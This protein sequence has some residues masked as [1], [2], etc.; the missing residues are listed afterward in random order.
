LARSY[1]LLLF[2]VALG[3]A[4]PPP[5]PY[6]VE[7]Y[8]VRIDVDIVEKRLA[9]E[10]TM[11]LRS[12]TARLSTLEFDA[13][14]LDVA[15]VEESQVPQRFER[16]GRLLVVTLQRVLSAGELRKLTM[17]YQAKPAKGLVFFPDQVY[18]SFF[19]NDWMVC[20]DRPEDRATLRLVIA[21]PAGAKVTGSGRLTA[22]REEGGRSISEW[23]LDSATPPFVFGFA[24]GDYV[25]SSGATGGVKLRYLGRKTAGATVPEATQAALQFLSE[26]TGQPF[27]GSVYT[28]VFTSGNVMQEV[29][30]FTLMPESYAEK[31]VTHPDDLW[32]LVHEL[33][34]QWYGIGI[35]CRDWSD[36]WLN[37]GI[38]TYVADAF[39][40]QR[41][42]RERYER[43]IE[44]SRKTYEKL[45][46]E[47]KDRPLSYHD[48]STT[49]EAGGALPYHKGAWVLHLLREQTGDDVFW[50]G[51]RLYTKSYWRKA[52]TSP[53]FQ[54]SIEEAAGKSLSGFFQKWVY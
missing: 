32:L 13:G 36:F 27:P 17:R 22:M 41:F 30:A 3:Q 45:K 15:S 44:S 43:E 54:K 7:H 38:A 1:L 39:L 33:A 28:Q 29:A 14:D 4:A 37:E 34:H 46:S 18:T 9:G 8:D 53:D 10:V 24:V 11:R 31:L 2:V 42:G 51:L 48:W 26:K 25:E 6:H 5:R 20:N 50:R 35:A 19:T 12:Q 52:V 16:R 47:G 23:A 49:R 21:A 40:E